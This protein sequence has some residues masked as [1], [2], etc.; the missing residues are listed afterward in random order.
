MRVRFLFG[1]LDIPTLAYFIDLEKAP[2]KPF[3]I[4]KILHPIGLD[5]K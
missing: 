5:S 2:S 4:N 1:S 3:K